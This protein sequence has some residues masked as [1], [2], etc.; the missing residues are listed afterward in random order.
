MPSFPYTLSWWIC[1][2]YKSRSCTE[3]T[4]QSWRSGG[5]STALALFLCYPG[6]WLFPEHFI[7]ML[8]LHT[9]SQSLTS[10]VCMWSS[11]K[12]QLLPISAVSA[13]SG[14]PCIIIFSGVSR[15]H[16]KGILS[17][18]LNIRT[19]RAV[20]TMKVT[21]TSHAIALLCIQHANHCIGCTDSIQ[22]FL[23]PSQHQM[24]NTKLI[25]V[26]KPPRCKVIPLR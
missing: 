6:P 12:Y 2:S 3:P 7:N 5:F 20:S 21:H 19:L 1:I 23:Q 14:L 8:L 4:K 15:C 25:L 10:R 18:L 9:F 17:T 11:S 22:H 13:M 26:W 24:L 16:C